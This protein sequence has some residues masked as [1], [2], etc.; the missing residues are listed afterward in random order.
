[1]AATKPVVPRVFKTWFI[2]NAIPVVA[3]IEDYK[4]KTF[5]MGIRKK[6]ANMA[7]TAEKPLIVY[8]SEK[9]RGLRAKARRDQ[10]AAERKKA[11]KTGKSK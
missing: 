10:R 8:P 4:M 2:K 1:V 7:Q 6:F 11:T 5:L 9:H 3:K